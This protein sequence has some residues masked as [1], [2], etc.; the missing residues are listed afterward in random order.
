M[1]TTKGEAIMKDW[2]M[3][4][5]PEQSMIKRVKPAGQP[6]KRINELSNRGLDRK[7]K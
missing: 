2:L 3:K 1:R 5:S 4:A 7:Q 6:Q